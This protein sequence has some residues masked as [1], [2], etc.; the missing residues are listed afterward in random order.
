M[1]VANVLRLKYLG[2]IIK[3][4]SKLLNDWLNVASLNIKNHNIHFNK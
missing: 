2:P 1:I 3:S 4:H